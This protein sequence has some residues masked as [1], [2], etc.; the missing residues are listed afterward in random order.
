MKTIEKK[1]IGVYVVQNYGSFRDLFYSLREAKLFVKEKG[2]DKVTG[3]EY[4]QIYKCDI[5][6]KNIVPKN[7]SA[8]E[9]LKIGKLKVVKIINK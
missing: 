7:K 4:Y 8:K 6:L 1:F 3:K 2:T 9:V 5:E